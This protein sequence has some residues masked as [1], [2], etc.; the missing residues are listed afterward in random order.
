MSRLGITTESDFSD[1]TF[2]KKRQGTVSLTSV[3]PTSSEDTY[4]FLALWKL[5]FTLTLCIF[6]VVR[7]FG[8]SGG[9]RQ[10]VWY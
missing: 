8:S 3:A 1:C 4:A 7:S 9:S 10:A 6:S 5:S 2:V